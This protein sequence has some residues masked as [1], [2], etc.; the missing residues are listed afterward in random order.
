MDTQL[1]YIFLLVHLL[2]LIVGFGAVLVIDSVGLLWLL[3]KTR[4]SFVSKLAQITQRLIWL[5]WSGL[6]ISGIW[7]ITL[8]GYVDNLT[9]I[10]LFFV[11]ML[12]VNGIY[13]H[14]IRK[15]FKRMGDGR[16][17]TDLLKFRI[18]LATAVSQ[19]G[20]WGAITIGFLHR[21]WR[22]DIP[23]PNNPWFIVLIIVLVILIVELTGEIYFSRQ[24]L[25]GE[26]KKVSD[27]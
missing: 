13:M 27:L 2:S 23:W 3:K 22:H 25:R 5:G 12:G 8:K 15:I 10:K 18:G 26:A 1:F 6:V 24:H 14:Y 7:L 16:E 20:W 11:L 21:N 17:M 9:K 4:T 19:L